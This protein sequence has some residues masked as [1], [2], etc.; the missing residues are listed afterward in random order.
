MTSTGTTTSTKG[1]APDQLSSSEIINDLTGF[2][3]QA[4]K[5][6]FGATIT[7]LGD[8]EGPA[9]DS[10][11]FLRACLFAHYRNTDQGGKT[12]VEKFKTVQGMRFGDLTALFQGDEDADL[13]GSEQ[14][15]D[16]PAS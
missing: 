10:M 8:D 11:A 14:G 12:D 4:I 7:A 2:D 6:Q 13:P 5:A 9:Y 3:E 15:K 16:A 1:K